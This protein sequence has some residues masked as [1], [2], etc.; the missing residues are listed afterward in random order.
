M[1]EIQANVLIVDDDVN[2]LNAAKRMFH[3]DAD[4]SILTA[5]E[6]RDAMQMLR[7][8]NIPVIVSDHHM[9]G[10]SGVEFLEW[11]KTV[12]RDSMRIL[13]TGDND[14][15]IAL[16]S[17]NRCEVF[18]FIT[19]P[20][21]PLEFKATIRD[22]LQRYRMV[23]CLRSGDEAKLLSLVRTIELKDLYTKGH[24][25]RV[26]QYASLLMDGL[27]TSD[28]ERREIRYGC[29]LHDCGKI[30]IPES[31]LNKPG[32][33]DSEQNE[34]MRNHPRWG[35]EVAVAAGLSQ[36]IVHMVLHHHERYDGRGYPEGL[37]G[38]RIPREAR[39]VAIA[40]FYDALASDRPYRKALK[41]S[42]AIQLMRKEREAAFDPQLVDLFIDG[43][44]Q[45]TE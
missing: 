31:I 14:F 15:G 19:K 42:D 8:G 5:S 10:M 9:P 29:L 37:S 35:S 25:E 26:A 12:A 32:S 36:R 27:D 34:L 22:A 6:V 11:S 3:G 44:D 1:A 17:I 43:M 38:H 24:S 2:V 18:R 7:G 45:I 4:I 39:I 20:W 13:L 28:E 30:G 41:P 40:D 16:N 23:T 21:N 33:L